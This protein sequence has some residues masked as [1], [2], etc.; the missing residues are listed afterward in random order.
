M[1]GTAV[2]A[3]N[4]SAGRFRLEA[5]DYRGEDYRFPA[6]VVHCRHAGHVLGAQRSDVRFELVHLANKTSNN[7]AWQLIVR[8]LRQYFQLVRFAVKLRM[9]T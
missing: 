9:S 4:F 7:V 2:A 3:A 6:S 8:M 5:I 1:A